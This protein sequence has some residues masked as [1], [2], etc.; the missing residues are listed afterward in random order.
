[1]A[2]HDGLREVLLRSLASGAQG[3]GERLPK[4]GDRG[5]RVEARNEL[6]VRYPKLVYKW[7]N[8]FFSRVSHAVKGC[9]ADDGRIQNTP[10][11]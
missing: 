3:A 1:M 11:C 10:S 9:N 5:M 2:P 7:A 8:R 4:K 6:V